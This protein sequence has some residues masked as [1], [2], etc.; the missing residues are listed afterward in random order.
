MTK[1]K[2]RYCDRQGSRDRQAKCAVVPFD[3]APRWFVGASI[4]GVCH[5]TATESKKDGKWSYTVWEINHAETTAVI[6]WQQDFDSGKTFPQVSWDA[7]YLWLAQQA[8]MLDWD[9]FQSW[10]R[11]TLPAT[12]ERWDAADAAEAEFG[13]AA[14][15]AEVAAIKVAHERVMAE[16]AKYEAEQAEK[17]ANSPFAA[18]LSLRK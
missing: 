16:K 17:R 6:Q 10:V 1:T 8:P 12:A 13:F 18:L 11:A 3:G 14:T 4:P 5:A 15:P 2:T 9:A 7:G